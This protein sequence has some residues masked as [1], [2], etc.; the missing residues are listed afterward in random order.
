MD[1]RHALLLIGIIVIAVVAL[2]SYD[3]ARLRRSMPALLRLRRRSA[4]RAEPVLA[5]D[6]NPAP[7]A[8]QDKKFLRA[9]ADI[10]VTLRPPEDAFEE[11][12]EDFEEA[13]NMPLPLAPAMERQGAR[14]APIIPANPDEKIDFVI[15]LPGAGPVARNAALGVYKQHEY[16]LE[17]PRR[18]YGQRQRQKIWTDL[19]RDPENA[20]YS[21]LALAIQLTDAR[22]PIGESEL[23][24]FVQVG[25]KLADAVQRPT[26]LPLDFDAALAR[27][28][29]LHD[30]CETYDVIA[31]VN[32]VS[33]GAAFAGRAIEQAA[34][35]LGMQFGARNIF[36]M[37]NKLSVGCRHLFSM[38]NLYQPGAFDPK[39]WDSF[40][41]EGL[42]L[43][44]SVPCA[45]HPAK[46]FEK[47]VETAKGLSDMLG[48]RLLDQERRPLTDKGII[49]IHRQ[50]EK[51]EN[52]MREQ[53]IV[54]GGETALRLFGEG[55][56]A[57]K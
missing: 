26:R 32:V 51:I 19:Q 17:K 15:H 7:P 42:T 4:R 43:F 47:M 6:I 37:K 9:D 45:H 46:V 52:K 48:G 5:L 40:H 36:H 20:E 33:G 22:G 21:D 13:A 38:A 50:I 2:V 27:A 35:R 8:R 14:L 30:F 1:L 54:A 55:V 25:L 24:A 10:T 23:N 44:M 28:K 41:T 16:K 57:G 11:K 34:R 31:G 49:V 3:R 53:G 18:L 12:L 39:A 56:A 29:A